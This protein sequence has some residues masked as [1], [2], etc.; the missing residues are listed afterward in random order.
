MIAKPRLLA[1]SDDADEAS[2]FADMTVDQERS[3]TPKS[4]NNEV[5]NK[6]QRYNEMPTFAH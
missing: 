2:A 5:A 1:I 4:T 3:V 6:H